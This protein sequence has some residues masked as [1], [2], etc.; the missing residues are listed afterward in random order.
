MNTHDYKNKMAFP[1]KA[2]YPNIEDYRAAYY[3]YNAET[4]RL[5][6]LFQTDLEKDNDMIGHPKAE[7]LF[8]KAW[9]MGHSAGFHE[10]K[11]H[12]EDLLEL[13]R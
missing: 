7:L 11:G 6:V 4:A 5:M 13:V 1:K 8:R 10:V 3:A 2:D 12:Y 9:E